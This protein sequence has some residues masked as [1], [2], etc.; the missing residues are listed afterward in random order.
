MRSIVS[1]FLTS[2]AWVLSTLY[3][4]CLP[5]VSET[6]PCADPP[7][8]AITCESGQVAI[9]TVKAGKVDG[10]C[11]TP[12]ANQSEVELKAFVLSNLTGK[13]VSAEDVKK[14]QY[15]EALR[16]GRL[17]TTDG[18]VVNFKIPKELLKPKESL[19]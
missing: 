17:E 10:R 16:Q 13:G 15:K 19:R 7:G 11:I 6:A 14:T 12:P 2:I 4:L 18:A 8:G 3:L 9:C 1:S 5:V